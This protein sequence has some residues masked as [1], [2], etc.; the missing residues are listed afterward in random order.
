MANK[1]KNQ[2]P[3]NKVAVGAAVSKTEVFFKKYGNLLMWIC[4]G[5]IAAVAIVLAIL[6]FYIKPLKAEA[7]NQT[8]VAEQYFRAD[9]FEKALNGDGNALGFAQIIDEYGSKGGEIVYFYAGVCEL[10][11]GNA[12]SA[13][14]YLEKYKAQDPI[15]YPRALSCI[16]DGYVMAENYEKGLSYFIKAAKFADNTFAASYLLKA[17]I[18]CE[19]L[20]KKADALKYYNEIKDKY[21]QTYEGYEIDKYI[22]RLTVE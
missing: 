5:V 10:K 3:D 4:A 19:E 15:L 16:G 12:E 1:P 17:G 9:D 6:Q 20:G 2:K 18:T 21:P 8:F 13:I 22:S 7:V 11:L 14:S